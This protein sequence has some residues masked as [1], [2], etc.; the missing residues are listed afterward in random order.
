[1]KNLLELEG[2]PKLCDG[3]CLEASKSV[4]YVVVALVEDHVN[5]SS[6]LNDVAQSIVQADLFGL[7]VVLDYTVEGKPGVWGDAYPEGA[8]PCIK[9]SN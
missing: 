1:M 2:P 8:G 5:V 7:V 4:V 3:L 6:R 9:V